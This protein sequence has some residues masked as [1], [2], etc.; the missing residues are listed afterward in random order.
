MRH[1]LSRTAR[2]R[3]VTLQLPRMQFRSRFE[4]AAEHVA[5]GV[6]RAFADLPP[7]T[8]WNPNGPMAFRPTVHLQDARAH[9]A[10]AGRRQPP[11][12]DLAAAGG[13]PDAKV[14]GI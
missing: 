4:E 11:Y 6:A 12:P 2:I 8:A 1:G 14:S 3:V 10:A 5:E 7:S 13:V 9:R